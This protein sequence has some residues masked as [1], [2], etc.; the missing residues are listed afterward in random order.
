MDKSVQTMI[1]TVHQVHLY[2]LRTYKYTPVPRK[3]PSSHGSMVY[4]ETPPT[5]NNPNM[6]QSLCHSVTTIPNLVIRC[7]QRTTLSTFT[8]SV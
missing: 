6:Q 3:E 5:Y 7:P 2:N 8:E 1:T 4:G